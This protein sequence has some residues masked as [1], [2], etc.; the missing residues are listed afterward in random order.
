M[1]LAALAAVVAFLNVLL[2]VVPGAAGVGHEDGQQ[3]AGDERAGQQAAQGLH[4]QDQAHGQGSQHRHDAGDQHLLQGGGGGDGHAGLVVGLAGALQDAGDGPELAADLLDHAVSGL[5]DG[6]HGQGGE[7]EGQ[8]AAQQQA[9]GDPGVQDVDAGEVDAHGLGVAH[10]E[11]QGGEGGGADGEALA[12][13]GGGVAHGVQLVGDLTDGVLQAAHLGDAAGVVGDGAVGVH[14]HGDAGGGE[15]THGGQSDAVEARHLV[16]DED[17]HADQQ[18]GHG[19]GHHAHGQ[20]ADDGGGGAGLRLLGDLLDG[21]VVAGG[22]DLGDDADDETHDEAGDDGDGLGKA[23]EEHLAQHQGGHH[24]HG[25]GDIGAHLQGL[26]G[27]GLLIAL[28]EEAADDGSQDAGRGQHQGE[29]GALG[30]EGHDAQGQSGDQRAHVALEEVC[31]HAGYV[32]HVVAHV[33]RDDGGVPGI[34]LGDAGLDLTH[35]VRANVRGLGVDAAAHA[36]EEGDG[37]GAQGEAGE[38]LHILGDG[39]NDRAAQQAQAHHAHAHDGAAGE[40][41]AQRPVHAGGPGGVRGADVGLGGNVHAHVARGHG[42]G[43]THQEAD[44]GLPADEKADQQAQHRHEDHQ[45]LILG[46]EEGVRALADAVRDLLHAVGA[47]LSLGDHGGLGGGKHQSQDG[48]YRRGPNQV[49]HFFPL[50]KSY[51]RPRA[52][53]PGQF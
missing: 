14:G 3:H 23:A 34:I 49:I 52:T 46:E 16:G 36:G 2:G 18:D 42:E 38:D 11:G 47:G 7:D 1:G 51:V 24:D 32:A 45:D 28:H 12:H 41:Q 27:I 44:G 39:V 48:Q 15:H 10:E 40:G 20:A 22:V 9:D 35:Q 30:L 37:G 6:L 4:A 25:G 17:A 33:V 53:G 29:D 19:G 31:A 13:G 50:L 26:V 5:G 8:H 43:G 21:L